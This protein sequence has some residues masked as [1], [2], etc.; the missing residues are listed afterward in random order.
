MPLDRQ[1][2]MD[3]ERR[4]FVPR[5]D[6]NLYNSTHN[7]TLTV[8]ALPVN[9]NTRITCLVYPVVHGPA[10][11]NTGI[12]IVIG[13]TEFTYILISLSFLQF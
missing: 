10:D 1:R 9:N 8:N 6:I 3:S 12:L 5:E 2:A 4:G 7:L 13:M 11:H